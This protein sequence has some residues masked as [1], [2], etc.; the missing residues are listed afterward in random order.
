M[1]RVLCV[2][3]MVQCLLTIPM[4]IILLRDPPHVFY[5][6]MHGGPDWGAF[7]RSWVES[8]DILPDNNG[9]TRQIQIR[10]RLSASWW[11]DEGEFRSETTVTYTPLSQMNIAIYPNDMDKLRDNPYRV[12]LA[13][14]Y[15]QWQDVIERRSLVGLSYIAGDYY[16]VI[17]PEY[18]FYRDENSSLSVPTRLIP[19]WALEKGAFEEIFDHLAL[20]NRYFSSIV[21]P[22]FVLI[23]V[24]FLIMQSLIFVAAVWLFG[25]WQKLSGNMTVRERFAVCTFASVPA[26]ALGLALGILFPLFHILLFQFGMIY[27][28]YKAMKE[29]LNENSKLVLQVL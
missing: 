19:A 18:I 16:L 4:S 3:F 11:T 29:Y 15:D 12:I 6:R 2:F 26:G 7:N 20:Y 1:V 28:S 23:F 27:F 9:F 10:R 17:T 25:H 24:V 22:T 8:L 14:R 13:P 5:P 21:A